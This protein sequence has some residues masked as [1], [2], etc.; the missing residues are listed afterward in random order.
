MC[1]IP[2]SVLK[3][4]ETAQ[5]NRNDSIWNIELL[6]MNTLKSYPVEN[7]IQIQWNT[8]GSL[9]SMFNLLQILGQV[10]YKC[11]KVQKKLLK[12]RKRHWNTNFLFLTWSSL[13]NFAKCLVCRLFSDSNKGNGFSIIVWLAKLLAIHIRYTFSPK[14]I[15]D[16]MSNHK[17]PV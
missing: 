3:K 12:P 5:K 2:K 13:L 6:F 4:L 10:V 17:N 1:S 7:G 14:I 11:E 15:I 9:D 8:I 16:Q